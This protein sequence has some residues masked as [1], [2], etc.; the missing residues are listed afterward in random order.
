MRCERFKVGSGCSLCVAGMKG[1]TH[2]KGH[3]GRGP[4]WRLTNG[5]ER[6]ALV[7]PGGAPANGG[8]GGA[9]SGGDAATLCPV[10]WEYL[11]SEQWEDG[12]ARLTST[13]LVFVE[14]GRVKVCLNDRAAQR[15]GWVTGVTPEA[16]FTA[17][18]ASLAAGNIEWRM[19]K[20]P[21]ET[22]GLADNRA[23]RLAIVP[24]PALVSKLLPA[25]HADD[26]C[27]GVQAC[28]GVLVRHHV[29]QRRH[30]WPTD[31]NVR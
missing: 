10:L 17:L 19:D 30:P 14:E 31:S 11:S 24:P 16:A 15:K 12:S 21:K 28:H 7:R 20:Q 26:V 5:R 6:M 9:L 23:V 4:T 1:Q 8:G 22:L 25:P 3:A 2:V 18:E 13:L 27:A 29:A